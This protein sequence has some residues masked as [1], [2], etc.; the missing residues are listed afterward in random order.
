MKD[1]KKA[2]GKAHRY[3]DSAPALL[4]RLRD[5]ATEV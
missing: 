1:K 2:S 5:L 3:L 4:N